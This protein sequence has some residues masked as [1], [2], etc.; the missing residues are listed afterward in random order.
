[1]YTLMIL[2]VFYNLNDPM[3]LQH[4]RIITQTEQVKLMGMILWKQ[5]NLSMPCFPLGAVCWN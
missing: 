1:M 3:N 5:T 2:T 4:T